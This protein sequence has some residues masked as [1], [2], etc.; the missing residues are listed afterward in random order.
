K[1]GLVLVGTDPVAVDYVV[2]QLFG[3]QPR[4]VPYLK[5]FL[6][7]RKLPLEIEIVGKTIDDCLIETSFKRAPHPSLLLGLSHFIYR[8][9]D[10][11]AKIQKKL[12]NMSVF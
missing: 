1:I 2:A 3:F 8:A 11:V 10:K 12:R 9:G 5:Y 6:K 4:R 7:H